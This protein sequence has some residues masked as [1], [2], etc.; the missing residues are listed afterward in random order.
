[1]VR[2]S[3]GSET[4]V[5]LAEGVVAL[6]FPE[7]IDLHKQRGGALALVMATVGPARVE[8]TSEI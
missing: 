5:D 8:R 6:A 1:M 2:A 7:G 3:G 4:P